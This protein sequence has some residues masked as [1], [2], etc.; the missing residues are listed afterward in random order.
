MI[1][2]PTGSF[3]VVPRGVVHQFSNPETDPTRM[4][5]IFS[6][7]GMDHLFDEAAEGRIPPQAT[8][9]APVVVEKLVA[10]TE[11]YGYEYADLPSEP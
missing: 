5:L 6:P 8:P 11:R 2:A 10:C 4:L 3:V 7:A 9:T 1:T